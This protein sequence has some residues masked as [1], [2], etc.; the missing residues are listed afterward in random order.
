MIHLSTNIMKNN[1]FVKINIY[2]SEIY[3]A[4]QKN[5]I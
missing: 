5:I 3:L 2:I 4:L 1:G